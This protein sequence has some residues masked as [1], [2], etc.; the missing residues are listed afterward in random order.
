VDLEFLDGEC[1]GVSFWVAQ[2]DGR[3]E[4]DV[5]D[6]VDFDSEELEEALDAQFRFFLLLGWR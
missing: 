2:C 4:K 5:M 6:A 3:A 1:F